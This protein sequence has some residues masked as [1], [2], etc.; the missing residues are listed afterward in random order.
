MASP[1]QLVMVSSGTENPDCNKDSLVQKAKSLMEDRPTFFEPPGS[2]A[3]KSGDL[4]DGFKWFYFPCLPPWIPYLG[5]WSTL[6]HI[7]QMGRN[8]QLEIDFGGFRRMWRNARSR[9]Q[10]IVR[11]PG[12][13]SKIARISEH[14]DLILWIFVGS[15]TW[16]S[17]HT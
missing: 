16:R 15:N 14:F 2:C 6:T 12:K 9:E 1:F 5:K 11:R 7:F 4:G 8:H 13:A 3:E 17:S 10:Q